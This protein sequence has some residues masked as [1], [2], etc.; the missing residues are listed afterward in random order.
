MRS[1]FL[2]SMRRLIDPQKAN[3]SAWLA[4]GVNLGLEAI[5]KKI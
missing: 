1:E 4:V 2:A 3:Q 5:I